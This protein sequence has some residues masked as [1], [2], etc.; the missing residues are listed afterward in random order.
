MKFKLKNVLKIN[1]K[2]MKIETIVS[3]I[4]ALNTI[5][6][7]KLPAVASYKIGK[8]IK[9]FSDE[10]K[11]YA[12]TKNKLL[13]QYGVP[14]KIKDKVMKDSKGNIIYDFPGDKKEK[15]EKE[16]QT[17]LAQ[18]V[19]VDIPEIKVADFKGVE[20]ESWVF[21]SLNWLIKE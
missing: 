2:R 4:S 15:F 7:I 16:I 21:A 19:D 10:Y 14:K 1:K 3:S 6:Q 12:E 8:M 11:I 20:I 5:S 13:E 18:E 9:N 17:L